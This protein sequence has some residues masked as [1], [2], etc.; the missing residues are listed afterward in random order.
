MTLPEH[1]PNPTPVHP[2]SAASP[3]HPAGSRMPQAWVW[4]SVALGIA[5]TIAVVS[6]VMLWQRL[7]NI[8]Q[9]LALQSADSRGQAVEARTL[10]RQAED[11]SRDT[12]S[13]MSVMEARVG[14]VAL[15]RGQLEELVHSLSR[16][17]D[18]TMVGD[19]ESA[20]RFAMQQSQ[21]SGSPDPLVSALKIA[22]QRVTVSAQPRLAPLQRAIARDLDRIA[23]SKSLDTAGLLARMDDLM[24]QVDDLPLQNDVLDKNARRST[25]ARSRGDQPAAAAATANANAAADDS[26]APSWWLSALSTAWSVVHEEARSLVRVRRIDYPDAA[27]LS[28]TQAFF[29]RENLKLRIMNARMSLLGRQMTAS[30]NDLASAADTV[31]K[32]FDTTSRRGQQAAQ[33]LIGLQQAMQDVEVPRANDTLAALVTA[34]AGR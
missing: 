9:Q 26:A 13:R 6:A 14:E 22:Q 18:D 5:A 25:P 3:I 15:Q 7:N 24:R 2:A 12:A 29:V 1:A 17:R 23:A 4:T 27:L 10:A 33:Q 8:Q 31:H 16:N 32:Y 28:P 34:A 30:R 19:I 21:L 11:V 20:I